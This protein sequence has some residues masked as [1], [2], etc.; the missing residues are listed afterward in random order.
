MAQR[1]FPPF[2][3]LWHRHLQLYMQIFSRAL[4]ELSNTNSV[5]GNEDAIS[6]RLCVIL[7]ETCF[8]YSKYQGMEVQTPYW[9]AA[10]QPAALRD[11][12]GGKTRKRPDFTCKLLNPFAKSPDELEISLHIECKRLGSPT[13]ASWNLN[14]NYVEN[15]MQRFDSSFHAYGKHA[16][17][18]MMIGYII[19]MTPNEIETEVNSFQKEYLPEWPGI[20]FDFSVLKVFQTRQETTRRNVKPEE[21]D[22]IHI[23]VDL[24]NNYRTN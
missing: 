9:E 21:F 16:P 15:G 7:T 5:S 1:A 23:W 12:K 8:N 3:K 22:L 14:K 19:N 10:I 24:R 6:E 2:T 18:G 4:H 13:S 17:S 20:R 11:L